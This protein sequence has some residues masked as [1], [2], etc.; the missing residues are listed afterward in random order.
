M[1]T[2][3]VTRRC[4]MSAGIEYWNSWAIDYE[5]EFVSSITDDRYGIIKRVIQKY[6]KHCEE[7]HHLKLSAFDFGCGPGLY[8][9][10]LSSKFKTVNGCELSGNLAALAQQRTS[11]MDNVNLVIHDLTCDVNEL[12]GKFKNQC[13]APSFGVC[14]NV[15]IAPDQ[16]TRQRILNSVKNVMCDKGIVLF[17]L[18]SLESALYCNYRMKELKPIHEVIDAELLIDYK[19]PNLGQKICIGCLPRD[20]VVTKHFLKEEAEFWFY[21]NGFDVLET[22][23]VCYSWETEYPSEKE[24]SS[25]IQDSPLPLPFDHVFVCRKRSE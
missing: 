23:K 11:Q 6:V 8:L 14:A 10:Y 21:S 13:T 4:E 20:G 15:L 9:P 12:F 3:S 19:L 7:S 18:P 5:K 24:V 1:S 2:G 16:G 25:W 17:V 22:H